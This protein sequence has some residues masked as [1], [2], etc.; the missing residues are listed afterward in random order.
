MVENP[1]PM[2]EL[3]EWV[4]DHVPTQEVLDRATAW[5][6]GNPRALEHWMEE[7]AHPGAEAD[8]QLDDDVE[9]K[10]ACEIKRRLRR[11]ILRAE[12][13]VDGAVFPTL[14]RGNAIDLGQASDQLV[15][16]TIVVRILRVEDRF[17]CLAVENVS[18]TT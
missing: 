15:T 14:Q 10:D 17:V 8:Y 7:T 4:R 2:D 13:E 18:P 1:E 12:F 5:L 11:S 6:D 16:W 3:L 9:A